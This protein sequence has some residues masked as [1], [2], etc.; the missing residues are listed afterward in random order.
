MNRLE[1]CKKKILIVEDEPIIGRLCSRILTAEGFDVDSV[2]NG[3]SA[4]EVAT[5]ENY[6]L[7]VSDIKLPGING[8][9]L[10]ESLKTNQPQLASHTIFMTGDSMNTDTQL[11][12]QGLHTPWL[13]KPFNPEELISA[14]RQISGRV[15][16]YSVR[17]IG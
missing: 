15:G 4:K 6:D 1:N 14:V 17:R 2:D 8:I 3:L 12:L 11:F 10:Y 7:C 13:M 5:S 16:S 9:Q